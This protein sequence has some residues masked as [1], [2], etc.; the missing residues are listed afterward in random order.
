[1]YQDF[2]IKKKNMLKYITD[3]WISPVS[4]NLQNL[5]CNAKKKQL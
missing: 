2:R 1:M 3:F 4:K 5:Q